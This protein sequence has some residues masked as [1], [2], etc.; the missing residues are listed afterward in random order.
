MVDRGTANQPKRNLSGTAQDCPSPAFSAYS[1]ARSSLPSW[2]IRDLRSDHAG[3]AGAVAMY[4]GILNV[5]RCGSV[6]TFASEHL[7]TESNH[8]KLLE[9][10]LPLADRSTSLPLWTCAGYITGGLPA[11]F[12][13]EAVFQ[14]I[15]AVET[16]VDE[17]YRKQ[18]VRLN[19]THRHK[20]ISNILEHC[21][22]DEVQHRDEARKKALGANN[23][24]LKTWCKLVTFG[25]LVAVTIA[26][27]I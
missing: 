9:T 2:L 11:L 26:R 14:T 23:I 17:H 18:I 1:A 20:R 12:G 22:F 5:S 7:E 27:S 8:L 6:R 15:D 3:E 13:A 25:S 24:F 21:R 16:F 10:I 19:H 4:K